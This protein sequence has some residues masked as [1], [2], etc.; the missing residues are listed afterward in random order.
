VTGYARAPYSRCR[1]LA[2]TAET[3]QPLT[4][5]QQLVTLRFTPCQYGTAAELPAASA[6]ALSSLKVLDASDCA[7]FSAKGALR[8]I[9]GEHIPHAVNVGVPFG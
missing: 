7:P 1:R 6:A 9:M 4:A 3:M 2:P 8:W 5:L